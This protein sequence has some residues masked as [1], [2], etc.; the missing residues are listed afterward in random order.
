[1]LG[2][3]VSDTMRNIRWL[4]RKHVKGVEMKAPAALPVEKEPKPY[5]FM[6]A[7]LLLKVVM[8]NREGL[9]VN[10]IA[11][12]TDLSPTSVSNI[13]RKKRA[14]ITMPDGDAAIAKWFNARHSHAKTRKD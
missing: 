9:R 5:G 7:D 11:K 10:E 6:T 8:L 4:L 13:L 12:V 14:Y 2:F 1:M 3:D